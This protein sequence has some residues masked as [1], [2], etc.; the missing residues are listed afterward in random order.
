MATKSA[1]QPVKPHIP[2]SSI[3]SCPLMQYGTAD[4]TEKKERKKKQ[5]K[6]KKAKKV[7]ET[8]HV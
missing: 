5:R 8:K 4:C 2:E 1:P 3:S 6:S 7:G